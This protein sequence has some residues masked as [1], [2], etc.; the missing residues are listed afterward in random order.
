MPRRVR[1]TDET[2]AQGDD[3]AVAE[4]E[5]EEIGIVGRRQT[6]PVRCGS[7][8]PMLAFLQLLGRRTHE[9]MFEPKS[10]VLCSPARV[11]QL[12]ESGGLKNRCPYGRAGSNP[13]PGITLH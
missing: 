3:V 13:A 4:V 5:A 8:A 10:D 12:A 2:F 7:A 9:H 6:R 11:D 1:G